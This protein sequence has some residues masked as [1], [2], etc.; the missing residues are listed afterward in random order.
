MKKGKYTKREFQIAYQWMFGETL[1]QGAKVWKESTD[2]YINL[3]VDGFKDNAK[4]S[5]LDD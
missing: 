5:A 1:T 2:E 3:V 4:K